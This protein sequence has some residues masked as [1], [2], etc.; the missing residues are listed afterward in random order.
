MEV[1]EVGSGPGPSE[2]LQRWCR[3]DSCL[4]QAG[5]TGRQG[6]PWQAVRR[7]RVINSSTGEVVF[8][9]NISPSWSKRCYHHKIPKEVL[10]VTTE[11][12]FEPQ[13]QVTLAT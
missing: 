6:P 4:E 1:P 11:F 2:P 13:E 7:R 10:H 12:F 3:H 8:D 5:T 9:E